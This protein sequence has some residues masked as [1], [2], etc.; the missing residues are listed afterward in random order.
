MIQSIVKPIIV[1]AVGCLGAARVEI[2]TVCTATKILCGVLSDNK[3]GAKFD[4]LGQSYLAANNLGTTYLDDFDETYSASLA[5][6]GHDVVRHLLLTIAQKILEKYDRGFLGH[7]LKRKK[8]V[9]TTHF[10]AFWELWNL[11]PNYQAQR[12]RIRVKKF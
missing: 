9:P 12:K 11:L 2:G 3:L 6:A 7:F 5:E 4:K 8:L 10:I 1:L